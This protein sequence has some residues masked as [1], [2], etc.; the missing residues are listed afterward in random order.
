MRLLR[1]LGLRRLQGQ[2]GCSVGVPSLI[3]VQVDQRVVQVVHRVVA[4]KVSGPVAVTRARVL[5]VA[6]TR[7]RAARLVRVVRCIRHVLR[8]PAALAARPVQGL[9]MPA[10]VEHV[11]DSAVRRGLGLE[12]GLVVRLAQADLRRWA[13]RHVRSGQA[14]PRVVGVSSIR[15]AKKAR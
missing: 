3:A 12:R 13:R 4:I 6:A 15:R 11:Q 8:L 1:L 9:A 14:G 5:R 7:V 10:Q 2:A